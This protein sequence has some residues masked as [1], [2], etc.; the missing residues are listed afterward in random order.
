VQ[1]AEPASLWTTND[2]RS[3]S[4][5]AYGR[6]LSRPRRGSPGSRPRSSERAVDREERCRF[7]TGSGLRTPAAARSVAIQSRLNPTSTLIW[8]G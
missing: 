8:R 7:V 6:S 3:R 1:V 4:A 2:R 5:C